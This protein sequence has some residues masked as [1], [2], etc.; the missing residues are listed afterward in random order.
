M[1]KTKKSSK[2]RSR[3]APS[4]GASRAKK[5][6]S[7]A[8]KKAA[9]TRKRNAAEVAKA[10]A[11]RKERERQ[12]SKA[13][14]ARAKA[15]KAAAEVARKIG[16]AKAAKPKNM[17]KAVRRIG[18]IL[19]RY[20]STKT[21]VELASKRA[22]GTPW[23]VSGEIELG[24]AMD[25]AALGEAMEEIQRDA[26]LTELVGVNRFARFAVVYEGPEARGSKRRVTRDWTLSEIA[27]WDVCT[28]RAAEQLGDGDGGSVAEK[29]STTAVLSLRVWFAHT[30]AESVPF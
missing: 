23:A 15:A 9:A 12:R 11:A 29:Y 6:R 14:R 21:S 1:A 22:K 3:S 27:P 28:S 30:E 10:E 18:E 20:T 19:G 2:S 26:E 17:A 7:A 13:R 5:S 8:A 16:A 25:Y 4:S 24:T